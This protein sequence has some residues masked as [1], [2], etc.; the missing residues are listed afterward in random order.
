MTEEVTKIRHFDM[1]H[2]DNG[3]P[4]IELITEKTDNFLNTRIKLGADYYG[5]P[6]V[7]SIL[8]IGDRPLEFLEAMHRLLE[9][10]IAEVKLR[11]VE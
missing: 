6:A 7:E 4:E 11:L 8:H 3:G 5:Y 1:V 2:I 10:H 9:K